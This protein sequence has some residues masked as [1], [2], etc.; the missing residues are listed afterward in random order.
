M[1]NS[2]ARGMCLHSPTKLAPA[3]LASFVLSLLLIVA[4]G[5]GAG[6]D[7]ISRQAVSGTVTLDNQ[8]VEQGT[9]TFFPAQPTGLVASGLIAAGKY[10]I[11]KDV[12]PSPGGYRVVIS[13]PDP[14][15]VTTVSEEMP[16]STPRPPK[17]LIPPQYNANSTLNA[18]VKAGDPNVFDFPLKK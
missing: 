16:G 14:K 13:A 6:E 1:H 7:K 9:I 12:G 11:S 10:E 2:F 4:P 8:P 18:E 5:C 3:P 15:T 17:D